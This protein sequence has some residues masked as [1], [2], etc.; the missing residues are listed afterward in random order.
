VFLVLAVIS[1]GVALW[2]CKLL[3]QDALRM[4]ARGL[5]KLAYRVEVHGLDNLAAAGDRIVIVPNHVSFLDGPLVAAVLPGSPMF[6]I[7]TAQAARWWIRPL[8]AGAAVFAMD[9][10]RPMMTKSLI[11]A[12]REDGGQ[13]VIF[14]E[15]RLNRTGGA[16]MKIYDGPALIADKAGATV[17][18]VRL[19]GV[20][21]TPFTRLGGRLRQRRFPKVTITILEP[22]RLAIPTALRGRARRHAAGV[23]L[24]DAMS[25]MM[26][27]RPRGPAEPVCSAACRAPRAWRP[28]CDHRRSARRA[29]RV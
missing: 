1:A 19:D 25:E 21:F 23:A 8:L 14:P 6:A 12:L 28:S 24:Y 3:P 4:L 7:D 17:L 5:F 18:P 27:R 26:A 20:E 11:K 9:P 2:I 16:L 22:R 10:A 15:G 13:C 29:A